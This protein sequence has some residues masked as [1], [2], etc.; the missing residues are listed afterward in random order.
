[1]FQK[2]LGTDADAPLNPNIHH[3]NNIIIINK[4]NYESNKIPQIKWVLRIS[5]D[6]KKSS[7][8]FARNLKYDARMEVLRIIAPIVD[9]IINIIIIT[10][11]VDLSW[12]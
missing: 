9:I 8:S 6:K 11:W 1:M 4:I 10:V 7:P 2:I 5:D 12:F 3:N